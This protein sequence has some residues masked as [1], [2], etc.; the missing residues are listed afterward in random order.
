MAMTPNKLQTITADNLRDL[1][2]GFHLELPE[3]FLYDKFK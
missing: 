2:K 1:A 3:R